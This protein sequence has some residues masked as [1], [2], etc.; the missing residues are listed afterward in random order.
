MEANHKNPYLPYCIR[1]LMI[2]WLCCKITG[3]KMWTLHRSFPVASP[4]SWTETIPQT[5][6][7]FLFVTGMLGMVMILMYPKAPKWWLAVACIEIASAL[8]DFNRWQPWN[9]QFITLLII[10][11]FFRK[12]KSALIFLTTLVLPLLI[13][14]AVYPNSIPISSG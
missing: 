3:W 7:L 6:H 4:I 14:T 13:F 12:Q 9:F 1:I 10:W 2:A 8:L 11:Y 5:F